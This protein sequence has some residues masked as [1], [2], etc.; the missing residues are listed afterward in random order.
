[1]A[2]VREVIDQDPEVILRELGEK[3]GPERAHGF[4]VEAVRR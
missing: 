1:V 3:A 4:L 2:V